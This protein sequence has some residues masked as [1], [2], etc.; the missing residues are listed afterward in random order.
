[1]MI[2]IFSMETCSNEAVVSGEVIFKPSL[3]YRDYEFHVVI[4]L[5][6]PKSSTGIEAK[7]TRLIVHDN[8]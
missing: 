8:T 3:N 4:I 2:S 5:E 1:M 6:N 7:P